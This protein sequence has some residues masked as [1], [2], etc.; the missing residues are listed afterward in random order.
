VSAVG[1]LSLGFQCEDAAIGT[2][3]LG[4]QCVSGVEEPFTRGGLVPRL[5]PNYRSDADL[6]REDEEM[7]VL[8][9]AFMEIIE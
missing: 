9:A 8:I 2:M 3:S 1:T 6:R 4:W 5:D 7:L